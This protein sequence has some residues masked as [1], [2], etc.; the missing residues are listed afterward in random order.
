MRSGVGLG[1]L[2][3]GIVGSH[4]R[5]GMGLCLHL[6]CCPVSS[7]TLKLERG[8]VLISPERRATGKKKRKSEHKKKL[9]KKIAAS[10]V[11][12]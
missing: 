2:V 5:L 12:D 4:F 1:L 9:F 6:L 8:P 11:V 3:T 7:Y 10:S